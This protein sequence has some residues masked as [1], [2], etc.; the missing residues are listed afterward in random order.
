MNLS[1]EYDVNVA[2][3]ISNL[4]LFDIGD[5]TINTTPKNPLL[6]PI[7]SIIRSRV[8]KLKDAFNELI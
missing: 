5:D 4:S 7:G 8:N 1:D 6:V 3:N 2:F